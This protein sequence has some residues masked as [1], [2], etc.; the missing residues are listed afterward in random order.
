MAGITCANYLYSKGFEDTA[1]NASG[2]NTT[3]YSFYRKSDLN[4]IFSLLLIFGHL[5]GFN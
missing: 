3:Y 4:D 1:Y 5:K 2:N